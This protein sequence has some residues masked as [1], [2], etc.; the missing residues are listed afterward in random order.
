MKLV[1]CL[2]VKVFDFR[3]LNCVRLAKIWG[4]FDLIRL[5][6]PIDVNRTIGVRLGSIN[7]AGRESKLVEFF[8]TQ[9]TGTY[10]SRDCYACHST[11]QQDLLDPLL[12]MLRTGTDKLLCLPCLQKSLTISLARL[13]GDQVTFILIHEKQEKIYNTN[14]LEPQAFA[15][16]W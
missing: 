4:E 7:Y 5:S 9:E 2:I 3:T 1:L 6:N 8:T 12:W 16:V 10:L 13:K 11:L 15:Y 14:I